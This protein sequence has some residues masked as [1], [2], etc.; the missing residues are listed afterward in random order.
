MPDA[1]A[2]GD[3]T[4]MSVAALGKYLISCKFPEVSAEGEI[5]LSNQGP[6]RRA[7]TKTGGFVL[8]VSLISPPSSQRTELIQITSELFVARTVIDHLAL[9]TFRRYR[10]VNYDPVG[11]ET[12]NEPLTPEI[13]TSFQRFA[14]PEPGGFLTKYCMAYSRISPMLAMACILLSA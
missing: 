10:M 6:C 1:W 4:D 2:G 5:I 3:P 12:S 11:G 13:W 9:A 8:S 7:N 14:S